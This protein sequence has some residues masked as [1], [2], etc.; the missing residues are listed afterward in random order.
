MSRVKI[1]VNPRLSDADAMQSSTD[2][3]KRV[4][5]SLKDKKP[6]VVDNILRS[7]AVVAVVGTMV[8][9]SLDLADI[10][11]GSKESTD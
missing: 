6:T 7:L 9:A 2:R 1:E 8:N 4:N 5:E 10:F 3:L 11:S